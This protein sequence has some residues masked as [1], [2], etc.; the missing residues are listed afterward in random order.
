M[1]MIDD[2]RA[3]RNVAVLVTAQAFL[4]SQMPMYFV[5][6]GLAGQQLSPNVCLATLP[7]SM[8]VF[9]SM[10]TAPWLSSVMQKFG[11]RTGFIIGAFGGMA[12]AATCAY[13]LTVQ[14]FAMFLL[15]SYLMGIYM[16]SQGFF[17]FAATDTASDEFRPK[18]I[19]YVMAG[20]LAAAMIGPQLATATSM[21]FVVPFVGS[22]V[23]VVFLNEDECPGLS[24]GGVINIV[25]HEVE[26]MCPANAIPEQIELDLA[27]LDIGDSIHI[28]AVPLPDG[29]TPTIDD[30]D[31]TIA[32]IAAPTVQEEVAEGEG[33]DGIE[34]EAGEGAEGEGDGGDEDG[35]DGDS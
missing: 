12:G 18:A 25:R 27:G 19:S 4:G 1:T 28:S 11:R 16:S 26:L 6:G 3:K 22:Y 30:R 14:S 9:G 34:G 33:E 35:K 10:T 13:A 32:T 7:I 21:A 5:I 29:V 23:A 20:G 31:F 24:R 17:R 15:G 8:I 2:T